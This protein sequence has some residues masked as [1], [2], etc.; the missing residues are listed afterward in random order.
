MVSG[1]RV[2]IHK[3]KSLLRFGDLPPKCDCQTPLV[4]AK[5]QEVLA[6][7]GIRA[8]DKNDPTSK[9][10]ELIGF[11]A[12]NKGRLR[13]DAGSSDP[14]SPEAAI[15]DFLLSSPGLSVNPPFK[16]SGAGTDPAAVDA[17]MASVQSFL[18]KGQRDRALDAAMA[19]REWPMALLIG[20]IRRGAKD[21]RS[22]EWEERGNDRILLQHNI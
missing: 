12:N 10:W 7:I 17:C 14:S 2:Q 15:C 4:N 16:G 22:E 20:E 3:V 19:A 6:W 21:G 11:A 13:S 8:R 18:L 1:H 5:D 9:L